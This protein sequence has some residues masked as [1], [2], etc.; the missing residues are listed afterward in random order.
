VSRA[1]FRMIPWGFF[2]RNPALGAGGTGH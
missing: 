2:G 1:G